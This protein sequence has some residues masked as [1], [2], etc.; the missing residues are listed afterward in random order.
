MIPLLKR[1][2]VRAAHMLV[3]SYKHGTSVGGFDAKIK[4]EYIP[5]QITEYHSGRN[6]DKHFLLL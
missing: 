1:N 2:V 4:D 6:S 5:L 3:Q